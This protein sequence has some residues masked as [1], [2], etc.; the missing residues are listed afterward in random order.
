MVAF[1]VKCA[2]LL[3]LLMA[4]PLAA[5]QQTAVKAVCPTVEPWGY[6]ETE[7]GAACSFMDYV[8]RDAGLLPKTEVQP[9][10]RIL[11]GL[12][13]GTIDL[14]LIVPTPE[15]LELAVSLCEASSI[16]ISIAYFKNAVGSF[17]GTRVGTFRN[18]ALLKE[19]F[20]HGA[21]PVDLLTMTQGFKM[22]AAHR[23]T[24]TVCVQPGCDRAIRNAGLSPDEL[25]MVP[26]ESFPFSLLLSK[27]SPLASD[28]GTVEKLR[29]A[30]QSPASHRIL[31]ALIREFE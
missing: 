14:T 2:V 15:R 17:E 31:D 23:L 25:S 4:S 13:D 6:Q 28:A 7:E 3:A 9:I 21:E 24:G 5:A 19:F 8:A 11:H 10:P 16:S 26:V 22:L 18:G 29:A 27:Q 20:T 30:C 1:R 12:R